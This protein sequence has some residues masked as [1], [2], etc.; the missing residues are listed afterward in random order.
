MQALRSTVLIKAGRTRAVF[1]P[2]S[3]ALAAVVSEA[4]PRETLVEVPGGWE[5]C[6]RMRATCAE[7]EGSGHESAKG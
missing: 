3:T 7:Q 1:I 5:I 2:A 6:M 4:G